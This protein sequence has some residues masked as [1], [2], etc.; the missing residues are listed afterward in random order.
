MN[1]P[2]CS[3]LLV[4]AAAGTFLVPT[5]SETAAA[6]APMCHG[7]RATIVGHDRPHSHLIS[8][9]RR[10]DV[11]VGTRGVDTIR[12]GGGNDVVCA[13]GGEDHVY[14]GPGD[15][16]LYGGQDHTG[17]DMDDEAR[18]AVGDT[19]SGGP[20]DDLIDLGFDP[21]QS[22]P[23]LGDRVQRDTVSYTRSGHGVQL[24][25][26]AGRATGE[27]H[28]V[29]VAHAGFVRF[30]GSAHDDRILGTTADDTG[31][32]GP[33]DDI[34]RGRA[35]DDRTGDG[36]NSPSGKD[37]MYGG[38]GNDELVTASGGD[39][40]DGGPGDDRLTGDHARPGAPAS[41]RPSIE[42]PF[43]LHGG[44]GDDDVWISWIS[45]GD[46]ASGGDGTDEL[47][48]IFGDP[49]VGSAAGADLDAGTLS[50]GS[51]VAKAGLFES[52]VL[53]AFAPLNVTGSD[54]PDQ[55]VWSALGLTADLG[56]GDDLLMIG[57]DD[58]TN[59]TADGGAGTDTVDLGTGND[60]CTNVE[61]GP[62]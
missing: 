7:K 57:R 19:I 16:R 9:T 30:R 21:G 29:I 32:L 55:I 27:G 62:C 61:A 13:L 25:L 5:S 56:A 28:D 26:E 11:I 44:T 34:F 3:V 58:E 6:A 43:E 40:L 8:G 10:R 54:G 47:T 1:T 50:S 42:R 12:A 2:A 51:R 14:G 59:D 36:Y 23:G 60:T 18:F 37:R 39:L 45:D 52:Y 41:Y 20:G 48:V 22:A 31:T 33:G 4:L 38:P 46:K 49:R 35:G 17:Y 53:N 24:D 15:D